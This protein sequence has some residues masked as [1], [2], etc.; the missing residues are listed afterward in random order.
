M[1]NLAC[2]FYN[3]VIVRHIFSLTSGQVFLWMFLLRGTGRTNNSI[4]GGGGWG[5]VIVGAVY[6]VVA[7]LFDDREIKKAAEVPQVVS[8]HG[9]KIVSNLIGCTVVS[10]Q[11]SP[12]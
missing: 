2:T 3:C 9:I 7:K 4:R 8:R 11:I 6:Y 5:E 12:S 10:Y 1:A